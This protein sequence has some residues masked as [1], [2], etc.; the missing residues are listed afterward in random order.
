MHQAGILVDNASRKKGKEDGEDVKKYTLSNL[1]SHEVIPPGISFYGCIRLK[2]YVTPEQIGM[3][4]L[5]LKNIINAET[6]LGG[7]TRYGYGL[8]EQAES[9][10][11]T[12][13]QG[14]ILEEDIVL[15][16]IEEA[17]NAIKDTSAD[18]II[19]GFKDL[20]AA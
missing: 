17:E 20:E 16:Y 7:L 8:L 3:I 10:K 19:N 1:F 11:I 18:S 5:S 13:T 15:G 14:D 6:T 12:D 4:I 9:I 2:D